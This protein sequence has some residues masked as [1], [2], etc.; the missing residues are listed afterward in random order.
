M[1]TVLLLI[2][3]P[4]L[5]IFGLVCAFQA[6]HGKTLFH[7]G[8]PLSMNAIDVSVTASGGWVASGFILAFAGVICYVLGVVA[9]LVRSPNGVSVAAPISRT[10]SESSAP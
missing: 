1:K 10:P 2:G 5:L 7:F 6:F 9:V 3:S 4:L 8:Y